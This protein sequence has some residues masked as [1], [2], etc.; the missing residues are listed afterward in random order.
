MPS[1]T[2][3]LAKHSTAAD[4]CRNASSPDSSPHTVLTRRAALELVFDT[5]V[6]TESADHSSRKQAMPDLNSVPA[7]PHSLAASRRQ[8]SHQM[9]PPAS[10]QSPS[11]NILP[12]NQ[13]VVSHGHSSHSHTH[14]R[15]QSLSHGPSSV[16]SPQLAASQPLQ[17]QLA[18]FTEPGVG[19]GP[20]PLR[21]PRPL[22]AAELHTQLEKE[23]EAVVRS[24]PVPTYKSFPDATTGKPTDTRAVSST[25]G[26]ERVRRFKHFV[27]VCCHFDA[28]SDRRGLAPFWLRVQHSHDASAP[29]QFFFSV[30]EYRREPARFIVRGPTP[31]PCSSPAANTTFTAG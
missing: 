11:L 20:G 10:S 27:H 29:P 5:A 19:P 30:T 21:H 31:Y 24:S 23:Q 26:S 8:S 17:P 13:D 9:P 3:H 14:S 15:H 2:L 1:S 22:T 25:R 12:S 6:I 16:P 28:R 7:S 18:S 4:L